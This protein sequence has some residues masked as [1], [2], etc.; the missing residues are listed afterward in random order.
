MDKMHTKTKNVIHTQYRTWK[1]P[2][3]T[4]MIRVTIV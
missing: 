3:Y 1:N 2:K 4:L